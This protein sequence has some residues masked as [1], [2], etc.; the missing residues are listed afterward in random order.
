MTRYQTWKKDKD[1]QTY[2]CAR[3]KYRLKQ[4]KHWH[5]ETVKGAASK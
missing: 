1:V 5:P 3:K 4:Q 2:S